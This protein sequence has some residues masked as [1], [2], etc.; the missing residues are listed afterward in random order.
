VCGS[1]RNYVREIISM[2]SALSAVMS[3]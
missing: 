3:R 2:R 1:T